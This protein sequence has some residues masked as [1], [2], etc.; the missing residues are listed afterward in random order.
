[1]LPSLNEPV[2]SLS[3]GQ[4]QAVAVARAAV[5][6]SNMII[7][8]EPTAALGVR[9]TE[10]VLELITRMRDEKKLS[11]LLIS[12]NMP[13]VLRVADRI[14]V[15]RLGQRVAT[16]KSSETNLQDLTLTLAGM[17]GPEHE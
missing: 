3:G 9:Q 17:E 16:F 7:M 8:D 12:H 11:I 14:S 1:T 6:G 2:G 13:D 5:W 4:R 15:L 10:F